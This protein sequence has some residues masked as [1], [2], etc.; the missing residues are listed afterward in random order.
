MYHTEIILSII[1]ILGIFLCQILTYKKYSAK[2][3]SPLVAFLCGVLSFY[4]VI[5]LILALHCC[6]HAQLI[7]AFECIIFAI[8]PFVIGN[9]ASYKKANWWVSLQQ[10]FL[11]VSIYAII[12]IK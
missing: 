6:F 11:L 9:L 2:V 5:M 1:L 12:I 3:I 10:V 7:K 8:A 4:S